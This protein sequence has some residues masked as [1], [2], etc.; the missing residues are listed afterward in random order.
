MADNRAHIMDLLHIEHED[1]VPIPEQVKKDRIIEQLK[2]RNAE[3]SEQVKQTRSDM[4]SMRAEFRT[5]LQEVISKSGIKFDKGSLN[6]PYEWK[7]LLL[8]VTGLYYEHDGVVKRCVNGGIAK[9]FDKRFE[10]V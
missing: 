9:D 6:N 2:Q 1:G 5:R 7:P 10:L 4:E 8:V 3:L